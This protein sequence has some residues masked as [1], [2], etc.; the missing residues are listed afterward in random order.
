MDP[1]GFGGDPVNGVDRDGR[2]W[3]ELG[4]GVA[5][6]VGGFTAMKT[7]GAITTNV[8]Q[9]I[10]QDGVTDWNMQ[11]LKSLGESAAIDALGGPE[12]FSTTM[13]NRSLVNRIWD[14]PRN[15]QDI[16]GDAFWG[17]YA[18]DQM[19][20]ELGTL[21]IATGGTYDYYH[22]YVAYQGGVVAWNMRQSGNGGQAFE[23]FG[24]ALFFDKL[25]S[26]QLAHEI[27]HVQQMEAGGAR[28]GTMYKMF[29][30]NGY[31]L[32]VNKESYAKSKY[33]MDAYYQQYLYEEG[34]VDIYGNELKDL[35]STEYDSDDFQYFLD[36]YYND[37]AY[38]AF[39]NSGTEMPTE[40]DWAEWRL[41]S[42]R[43]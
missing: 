42:G 16:L 12:T 7:F 37:Y 21:E 26:D 5:S 19:G 23:H 27:Q 2:F 31:N 33:E 3:K 20:H 6:I 40:E 4:K 22:G 25:R 9:H 15:T 38:T 28:F 39:F 29:K 36:K 30:A 34:Y 8:A 1:Y 14:D 35:P 17:G 13:T 32:G 10:Y 18:I 24:H 11:D 41:W 43:E